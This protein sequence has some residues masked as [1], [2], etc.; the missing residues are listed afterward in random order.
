M[1]I[2]PGFDRRAFL[3]ASFCK[4]QRI[5]PQSIDLF[6]MITEPLCV[7][8]VDVKLHMGGICTG[9]RCSCQLLAGRFS[10]E[11]CPPAMVLLARAPP[12]SESENRPAC[13]DDYA[14]KRR[15]EFSRSPRSD[16]LRRSFPCRSCIWDCS[17]EQLLGHRVSPQ[18]S[19]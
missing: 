6:A 13:P 11:K 4:T 1:Q 18:V 14:W 17:A 9:P 2:R 12:L 10:L 16:R 19:S 8:A 15:Q 3:S 5:A 7:F